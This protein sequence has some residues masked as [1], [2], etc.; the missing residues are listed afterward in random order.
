MI[1]NWHNNEDVEEIESNI[2][3]YIEVHD[4]WAGTFC[5]DLSCDSRHSW[6]HW[7]R[8]SFQL[9]MLLFL[10]Y[11]YLFILFSSFTSFVFY[12]LLSFSFYSIKQ[13]FIVFYLFI[14]FFSKQRD[15]S[16]IMNQWCPCNW[17]SWKMP[18]V[19]A[20][21]FFLIS[22]LGFMTSLERNGWLAL[23]YVIFFFEHYTF[24]LLLSYYNIH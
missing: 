18:C 16:W 13:F 10:F 17:W 8:P 4:W 15:Q 5:H 7:L 22:L 19:S 11:H 20:M 14:C 1:N 9:C 24:Y 3:P 12:S 23:V 2:V 21:L 6:P